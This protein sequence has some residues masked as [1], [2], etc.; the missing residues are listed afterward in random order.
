MYVLLEGGIFQKE[1]SSFITFTLSNTQLL[2]A[3]SKRSANYFT[4][5]PNIDKSG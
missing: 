1:M 2:Q 4:C 3:L 5:F